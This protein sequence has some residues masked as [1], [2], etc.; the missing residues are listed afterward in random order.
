MEY[1]LNRTTPPVVTNQVFFGI[2]HLF[3]TFHLIHIP[4][5]HSYD[6]L[7]FICFSTFNMRH[8]VNEKWYASG[9]LYISFFKMEVR[10]SQ[11]NTFTASHSGNRISDK[12]HTPNNIDLIHYFYE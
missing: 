1:I 5:R 7:V 6:S 11:C 3:K 4:L 8:A 10:P 12:Q 9:Q 2:P